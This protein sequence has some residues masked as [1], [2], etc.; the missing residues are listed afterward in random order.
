MS[1]LR[2]IKIITIIVI[3][4]NSL[5]KA[6][7]VSKIYHQYSQDGS[8]PVIE[9]WNV[10][11]T[12]NLNFLIEETYDSLKRVVSIKFLEKGKIKEIYPM[13]G[14]S[15]ITFEYSHNCIIEKYLDNAGNLLTLLDDEAPSLRKYYLD[16]NKNIDSCKTDYYLKLGNLTKENIVKMEESLEFWRKVVLNDSIDTSNKD[17][18][19]L[20]KDSKC[21]LDYVYGYKYSYFK[22][23]GLFPKIDGYKFKYNDFSD[24]YHKRILDDFIKKY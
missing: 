9:K 10:K 18:L 3:L 12:S 15:Y 17:T 6:Q 19:T 5:V 13:Y 22:L 2:V 7:G 11:D 4:S 23:H 16:A 14:V 1:N 8:Y 24:I 20:N 21:D